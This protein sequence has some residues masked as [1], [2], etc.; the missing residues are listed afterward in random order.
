M[1][2]L[3]AQAA[4]AKALKALTDDHRKVL[5]ADARLRARGTAYDFEDLLNGAYERWLASDKPVVGPAETCSFLRGAIRS[6]SSNE[7]RHAD[8]VRRVEG[9]RVVAVDGEP[10][11]IEAAPDRAASQEGA[12]L[13]AQL[14]ELCGH[15]PEVQT[16]LMLQEDGAERA[17]ILRE[18][19]WEVTKYETV[20]KRKRKIVARL[21]NEGKI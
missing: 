3:A 11:P 18:L 5:V 20:Q 1:E 12:V 16:L 7:R 2:R 13:L 14:Y 21:I 10:D 4:R 9:D 19:G 8:L 17:D 6:I 15:D